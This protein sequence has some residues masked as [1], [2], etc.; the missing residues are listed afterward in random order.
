LMNQWE[1]HDRFMS[2]C[3]VKSTMALK[4]GAPEIE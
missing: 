4:D 3:I 1:S 2:W